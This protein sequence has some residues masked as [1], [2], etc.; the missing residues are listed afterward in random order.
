MVAGSEL[1]SFAAEQRVPAGCKVDL[2][3]NLLKS[4]PSAEK[5]SSRINYSLG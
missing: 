4:D 5:G 2:D 1:P 3:G